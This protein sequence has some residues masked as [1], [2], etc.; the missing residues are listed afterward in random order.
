MIVKLKSIALR[1]QRTLFQKNTDAKRFQL[2]NRKKAELAAARLIPELAPWTRGDVLIDAQYDNPNYWLRYAMLRGAL[3]LRAGKEVGV[4]GKFN[5]DR[6]LAT[7]QRMGVVRIERLTTVAVE[8]R[9]MQAATQLQSA[10][11]SPAD[12]LTAALPADF[13]GYL[14]YDAI[15]K[16]QRV[17]Q[18][19]LASPELHA[20]LAEFFAYIEA[21]EE[22]FERHDFKLACVSHIVGYTSVLAWSAIRRKI[23]VLLLIGNYGVNRFARVVS[24]ADLEDS[25]DR[26]SAAQ[27]QSLPSDHKSRLLQ[28]GAEYMQRRLAGA[29]LDIGGRHAYALAKLTVNK[30]ELCRSFAWDPAKPIIG[31]YASN[32]FDFPHS[33]GMQNFSDFKDWI[34]LT[35]AELDRNRDANW[36]LRAHPCDKWYGGVTL[37]DIVQSGAQSHIALAPDNLQ[38]GAMMDIVDGVVTVHGTAGLEFAA[39]G[40]PSLVADRGWYHDCAFT[41]WARTRDEYR[42]LLAQRWWEN[43]DSAAAQA[44]ARTFAGVYFCAP[45]WQRGLIQRDDSEQWSIY[46]TIPDMLRNNVSELEREIRLIREW[47]DS[48]DR[49]FH[50][51]KMLRPD[52][53]NANPASTVKL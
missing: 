1:L 38:G 7:L 24:P 27:L 19:D 14:L 28:R 43:Y 10:L 32:W 11:K 33:C 6:N 39:A 29:T 47:H 52:S 36:L 48:G 53:M 30:A 16:S 51:W 45:D 18:P 12:L 42:A 44:E 8:A 13:P 2:A 35:L 5:Q 20:L 15:L 37:K 3:G 4:L 17:A 50:T 25:V 46:A 40:K 9:H 23:P 41:R 26:P 34:D 49:F 31:V 22:L 21:S